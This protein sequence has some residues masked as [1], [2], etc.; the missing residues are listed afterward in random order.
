MIRVCHRFVAR[1]LI[2]SLLFLQ[3]AVAAYACPAVNPASDVSMSVAMADDMPM[4]GSAID[5]PAQP[6][7]CKQH[8]EQNSQVLDQGQS[9]ALAIPVLPLL[10]VVDS[11]PRFR[12]AVSADPREFLA[13]ATA[14]PAAIR[15][16][17][18]RI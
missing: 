5:D 11:E 18:F 6:N 3:L 10:A 1:L 13:R 17:V 14:P 2:A 4:N 15:F 9:A 12:C 16:C 8:C 7:L